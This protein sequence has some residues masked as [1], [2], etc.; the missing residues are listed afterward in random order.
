MNMLKKYF[1]QKDAVIDA[2]VDKI[3]LGGEN[4]LPGHVYALMVNDLLRPS[5]AVRH[6][7]HARLLQAYARQGMQLFEPDN[8]SQTEYYQNALDCIDLFGEYFPGIDTAEKITL[9]AER[10]IRLFSNEDISHLPSDGHSSDGELIKV[11]RIRD[12]DCFQLI[13]GNHRAAF[14]SAKQQERIRCHLISD[15]VETTPI[16]FLLDT[17][18]WEQGEKILYQPLPCPELSSSWVQAR[19]CTD[20]LERMLA[21]LSTRLPASSGR[22]VDLGSYYGW[23][24]SKFREMGFAAEGVEKDNIAIQ[25]GKIAYGNLDFGI[26]RGDIVR[27]LKRNKEPYDV[28]C[29]LSIM[30]HLISGRERGDPV[31]LLK[32][33]DANTSHVFFFEMGEPHESWFSQTLSGWSS[34]AIE[35]WVLSNTSFTRAHQLGRDADGVGNF[36]GNF[37]RMLFAFEK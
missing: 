16:Q 19:K 28:S 23:F 14:A 15:R 31:E 12:S 37:G 5:K 35:E 10:F 34:T 6:G 1:G 17:L 25:I 20:R 2:P 26:H 18:R 7:P 13:Q 4:D 9:A 8:L 24:V 30:H 21:F 22:I 36:S 29:C 33:I 11:A 3:L 32:L 27:F